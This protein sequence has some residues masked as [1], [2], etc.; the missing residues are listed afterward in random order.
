[1]VGNGQCGVHEDT[2]INYGRSVLVGSHM[3]KSWS[4]AQAVKA[5]SSGEAKFYAATKGAALAMGLQSFMAD[6]GESARIVLLTDSTG[7][8]GF[9]KRRG[10]G[11]L[12]HM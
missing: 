3:I 7:A 4:V 12:R 1:M 8:L 6:W 2:Q 10:L 9:L 5:L 11:G